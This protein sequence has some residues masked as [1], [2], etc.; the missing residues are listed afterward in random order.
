MKIM[1]GKLKAY[2]I[3]LKKSSRKQSKKTKIVRKR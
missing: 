3:M 1:I 2:N